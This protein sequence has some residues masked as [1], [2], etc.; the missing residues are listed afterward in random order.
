MSTEALISTGLLE[1]R[2]VLHLR[3]EVLEGR[4][5]DGTRLLDEVLSRELGVSRG[6]IR[7]ALK[8]LAQEGLVEVIPR[9]GVYV[10]WVPSEDLRE[11][12]MI[13]EGIEQVALRM[14]MS[15]DDEEFC[16]ALQ[17]EVDKMRLAVLRG[18]W[19]AIL[20]AE[21]GFHDAIYTFSGSRRLMQIWA[22]LRPTVIASFRND[23]G[24]HASIEAVPIAHQRLADEVFS[25]DQV[26]ATAELRAHIYPSSDRIGPTSAAL[27]SS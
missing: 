26:R 21:S 1:D 4:L 8:V 2:V 27:P 24:Y 11:V 5:P 12:V 25:G 3:T 17:A 15:R 14:A 22:N 9:R 19:E 10:R 16:I 7:D 23:R 20:R 6:P 13:R 18:D